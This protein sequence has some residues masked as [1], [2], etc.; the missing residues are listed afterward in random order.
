MTTSASGKRPIPIYGGPGPTSFFASRV[1]QR[2]S[3]CVYIPRDYDESAD[4]THPL[5]V[6][7]H[8]SLRNAEGYRDRLEGFAEQ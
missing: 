1:D 2:F 7:V 6:V 5:L 8:G 4:D 3:Y